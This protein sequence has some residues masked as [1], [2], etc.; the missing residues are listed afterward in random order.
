MYLVNGENELEK[1]IVEGLE[2]ISEIF[3]TQ[4]WRESLKY[5]LSPTQT[6]ILLSLHKYNNLSQKELQSRILIDKTTLSKSITNLEHKS[7][8]QRFVDSKDQR[9]K[10]IRLTQKGIKIAEELQ[11]FY[12]SFF[13]IINQIKSNIPYEYLY[14]FIYKFIYYS[15]ELNLIDNQRMCMNCHFFQ[16]K[17][18]EYYCNFLKQK[19]FIKDLQIDCVDFKKKF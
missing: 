7:Y 8:I 14:E 12:K 5:K 4:L 6:L 11:Y 15:L 1:K 16:I 18:N 19:L 17:K 10:K 3:R 9:I 2:R 13:P